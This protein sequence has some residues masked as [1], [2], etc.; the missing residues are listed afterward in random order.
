MNKN[1]KKLSLEK[2]N[3]ARLT[4]STIFIYGGSGNTQNHTQQMNCHHSLQTNPCNSDTDPPQ[5]D[6]SIECGIGISNN[7][8]SQALGCV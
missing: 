5:S 4:K 7:C 3:I 1:K 2:F 6:S 8:P